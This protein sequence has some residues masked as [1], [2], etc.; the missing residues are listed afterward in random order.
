[1]KHWH[2]LL[3]AGLGVVGLAVALALTVAGGQGALA[4]DGTIYVDADATSGANDGSSWDDAYTELQPALDAA[5]SG[6]Q[7]WVAEG[8]FTPTAQHGGT[9][10]R[11]R[12]FQ[13]KNGVAIYGG[14]DPSVGDIAF[15]DRDWVLHET[16]LS[17]DLDG[18]DG[19]EFANND[20]NS[21]HV[22]YHPSGTDLDSTA[23]L[24]GFTVSGGNANGDYPYNRG[25][26]MF[27]DFSS[28]TLTHCTFEGNSAGSGGGGMWNDFSSPTLTNCTFSG[29]SA[30][31]YGYGGGM[32]N[33]GSAPTLT[34]C[35]FSANSAG[36]SGGGMF[37]EDSSPTLT[38]CTFSGNSANMY[39]GG[40]WND[41][42]SP[43]LTNC[44]FSDNSAVDHGGGMYNIYSSPTLTNCTF[45]GNS[46]GLYGYGGGMYNDGSS[47]ALT[48]CTFAGN[49]AGYKAGG[50]YNKY[51][52]PALTNCIFS[53][54]SAALGGGMYNVYSSPALTNCTFS[55]NSAEARGGGMYN[56]D[57]SPTLTNCTFSDNSA[58]NGGGMYNIAGS[59]PTLTNCILWGDTP[60][61]I[62]NYE[63]E[64]SP[65]VT[66]SDIQSGYPGE[67]N[68]D[69]Y[70]FFVD[71]ANG[72]FHLGACS[73]CID[74][75]D[76]DAPDLPEYDF[77]GDDRILDGDDD[78]TATVD[79]GVDEVAVVG[80]CF[81]VYLPLVLR[82]Y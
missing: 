73:R 52:S 56:S 12:S 15:E 66:H 57:S 74:A 14:F 49:S 10:D 78:G 79:M 59:S 55:G 40:M 22:F 68:I 33:D 81:R 61:E 70:P 24:D 21:Y 53:G 36:D 50:M 39:G 75:G 20:E 16:I 19:P 9:G 41:R 1:M 43:T 76:N 32:R 31:L 54:N 23:I 63:P 42:S 6:D 51:S 8:T 28:P 37:N 27:N 82:G 4:A 47:P 77:E 60:D 5:L 18:D 7:I 48:N 25:G 2:R 29:N 69:A 67:G 65:V 44:T 3:I 38:N 30:G 26:G 35:T 11:Y 17:G 72:D 46:A 64:S 13:M 71:A 62:Y 34:N 80:T 45:S 58:S